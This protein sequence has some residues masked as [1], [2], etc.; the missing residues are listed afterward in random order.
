M[1][2]KL[3]PQKNKLNLTDYQI[4]QIK[5]AYPWHNEEPAFLDYQLIF[6]PTDKKQMLIFNFFDKN[7]Q[8]WYY[9]GIQT[10]LFDAMLLLG[11]WNVKHCKLS[12]FQ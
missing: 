3:S 7:N 6:Q 8:S 5:S 10:H 1:S 11:Q 2:I 9:D 4:H 12:S